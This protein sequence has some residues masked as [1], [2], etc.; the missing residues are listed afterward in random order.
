MWIQL[1]CLKTFVFFQRKK[2]KQLGYWISYI[3]EDY[4]RKSKPILQ[5]KMPLE[6]I[7]NY[8]IFT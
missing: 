6:N 8:L 7:E 5:I 1:A 2:M 3:L 4:W